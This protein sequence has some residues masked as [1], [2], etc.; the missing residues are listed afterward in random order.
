[1][2]RSQLAEASHFPVTTERN[3]L[4]TSRVPRL[5]NLL[6]LAGG[7]IPDS[8]GAV[9][10]RR[11]EVP[12]VGTE[13]HPQD[14]PL[15]IV[16]SSEQLP[17]CGVPDPDNI[18]KAPRGDISAVGAER[19]AEV[20]RYVSSKE[21]SLL[22]AR[23][24]KSLRRHHLEATRHGQV[25][26]IGAVGH[27]HWIRDGGTSRMPSCLPLRASHTRTVPS[28][29]AETSLRPSVGWKATSVTAPVCPRSV[30][31][32]GVGSFS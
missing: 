15:V 1:M 13:R 3:A 22:F 26:T 19:Y 7:P 2:V 14:R 23:Y 8:H 10:A 5:Q 28:V 17:R 24:P 6:Y 16:E 20:L 32:S 29:P 21:E 9:P 18:I 4:D 30:R 27:P 25:L 12:T 11:G 31:Y